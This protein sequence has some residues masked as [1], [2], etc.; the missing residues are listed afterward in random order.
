MEKEVSVF[1]E[2]P[3]SKPEESE[4]LLEVR[5]D[6]S[7]VLYSFNQGSREDT[8]IINKN[9]IAK[10]VIE[11]YIKEIRGGSIFYDVNDMLDWLES[12]E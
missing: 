6:A 12:K 9:E 4:L 8:I 5:E 11:E 2:I 10:Q 7:G 1:E 3:K